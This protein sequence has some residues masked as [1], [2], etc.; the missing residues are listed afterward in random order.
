MMSHSDIVGVGVLAGIV[1]ALV[2]L[3]GALAFRWVLS[4][5]QVSEKPV[6]SGRDEGSSEREFR[7]AA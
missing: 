6:A 1:F 3:G 4:D 7:R 2:M 5:P